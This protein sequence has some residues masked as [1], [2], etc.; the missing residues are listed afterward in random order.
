MRAVAAVAVCLVLTAPCSAGDERGTIIFLG[1][2]SIELKTPK[3][4]VLKFDLGDTVRKG[5]IPNFLY[6]DQLKSVQLGYEIRL[7]Y[8]KDGDKLVCEGIRITKRRGGG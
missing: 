8:R 6:R 4:E 5:E 2:D 1:T 3:G 7:D